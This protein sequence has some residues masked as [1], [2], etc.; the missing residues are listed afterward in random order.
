MSA[1]TTL[2]RAGRLATRQPMRSFTTTPSRFAAVPMN[3]RC[4]DTAEAYRKFQIEKPEN[5]HM[6][7][8]NSTIANE[9]PSIGKDGAPPE[10]ITSVDPSF[11]PKD[12][13]PDNT[14]KMMGGQQKGAPEAGVNAELNV[15]EIEGGTF[16]IEPL[17]RTG[18]DAS[19]MRARLIYQSR[20]RGTLE[21]DLLL[22]TF[23]DEHLADMT[24]KQLQQ[25]DLFLDE[26]DWDI[27]YWATQEPSPTS[28]AYA[29]GAGPAHASPEA[30]GKGS[31]ETAEH[32]PNTAENNDLKPVAP[33]K[34]E[35][36]NTLGTF[37]P[38]Y[39]PVP[40]RWK[41]SEILSMLRKHVIKR[42]AG[43][44]HV[45]GGEAA[46]KEGLG[47]GMAFMPELKKMDA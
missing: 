42:S 35:W 28:M 20:K 32:A 15:G 38:A 11:L 40:Q 30:Q 26:N 21:S 23:A 10:M 34:G 9:M 19:T 22:S 18:E 17:K 5:P 6:T 43:G 25:Y 31:A 37:K 1:P 8:T 2:L 41:N 7:N 12:S 45:A 36:A 14:E 39:R 29:E 47:Q 13:K 3:E 27:Y 16:R 46:K 33:A 24:P 4:N 44:V